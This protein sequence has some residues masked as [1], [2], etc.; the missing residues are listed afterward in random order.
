[1]RRQK[2]CAT[3]AS[4]TSAPLDAFSNFM[5]VLHARFSSV[6]TNSQTRCTPA[7]QRLPAHGAQAERL[8]PLAEIHEMPDTWAPIGDFVGSAVAA[9]SGRPTTEAID[10]RCVRTGGGVPVPPPVTPAALVWGEAR[11][12]IERKGP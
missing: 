5:D 4:D 10:G 2:S 12:Q 8:T 3:R 11:Q 7:P 9:I 6:K 1:M